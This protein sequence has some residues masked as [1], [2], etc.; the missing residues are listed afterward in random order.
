MLIPKDLPEELPPE[1]RGRFVTSLTNTFRLTTVVDFYIWVMQTTDFK[2]TMFEANLLELLLSYRE[3]LITTMSMGKAKYTIKFINPVITL[4]KEDLDILKKN[5]M[6]VLN[7]HSLKLIDDFVRTKELGV[8][9]LYGNQVISNTTWNKHTPVTSREHLLAFFRKLFRAREYTEEEIRNFSP[10]NLTLGDFLTVKNVSSHYTHILK[11]FFAWMLETQPLSDLSR[12]NLDTLFLKMPDSKNLVIESNKSE[13]LFLTR[14]EF[15]T[16]LKIAMETCKDTTAL[17]NVVYLCLIGPCALRRS[18][19]VLIQ[20]SDFVL[21]D[22]LLISDEGHGYG[23]LKLPAYKSKGNYSPS[24]KGCHIPVLPRV[25]ELINAY[26]QSSMMTGYDA[27]TFL[28]RI[29]PVSESDSLVENVSIDT[30]L[31]GVWLK[32]ISS[33]ATDIMEHISSRAKP[34]LPKRINTISSHVLRR[35]FNEFVVKTPVPLH[36]RMLENKREGAAEMLLRHRPSGSVNRKHYQAYPD[37]NEFITIIDN[38]LNFQFD[39]DE[40]RKWEQTHDIISDTFNFETSKTTYRLLTN[41]NNDSYL[42][43]ANR[44]SAPTVSDLFDFERAKKME[45]LASLKAMLSPKKVKYKIEL[46]TKIRELEK[47][48]GIIPKE[49]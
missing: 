16:L 30:F 47:D 20:V 17:R 2:L 41:D 35:T 31:D 36:M 45:E 27:D 34:F 49:D 33:R 39:L 38:A 42:F 40:L 14:A 18:E 8:K 24:F 12:R 48:L 26:L 32:K 11:Q 5:P 15:V 37:T 6:P 22:N 1:L 25:R 4:I 28:M 9:I 43:P 19:A 29:C 23:Q 7:D 21:D 46:T 10:L 44:Q 3:H 13:K